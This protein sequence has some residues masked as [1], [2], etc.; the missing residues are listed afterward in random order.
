MKRN[1][2]LGSWNDGNDNTADA[3]SS[4]KFAIDNDLGVDAEEEVGHAEEEKEH[5]SGL[6]GLPKKK[7]Q[8]CQPT[9]DWS[10]HQEFEAVV[11]AGKS[12]LWNFFPL[13]KYV[14]VVVGMCCWDSDIYSLV[15]TAPDPVC[16]SVSPI[17]ENSLLC[18][19]CCR[20]LPIIFM[21]HFTIALMRE[22][23]NDGGRTVPM[24][25]R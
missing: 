20:C 15:F 16:E 14:V 21:P 19:F 17:G 2:L 18:R 25:C 5:H 3:A 1:I 4:L 23:L 10:C 9:G 13:I 7:R 24:L 12:F 11:K 6:D 22:T 8:W